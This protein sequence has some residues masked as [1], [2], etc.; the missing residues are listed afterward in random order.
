MRVF[1]LVVF[2]MY[3]VALVLDVFLLI[4]DEANDHPVKPAS[5][6]RMFIE[7]GLMIWGGLLLWG[8]Q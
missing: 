3:A 6:A 8:G 1:I 5:I 4:W 2:L 7:V